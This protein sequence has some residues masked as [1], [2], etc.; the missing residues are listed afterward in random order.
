MF[1]CLFMYHWSSSSRP[2][3]FLFRRKHGEYLL[4]HSIASFL[5]II[6]IITNIMIRYLRLLL[7]LLSRVHCCFTVYQKQYNSISFNS[8]HVSSFSLCAISKISKKG[9]RRRTSDDI[10]F[11]YLCTSILSFSSS[12]FS[13]SSS[14]LYTIHYIVLWSTFIW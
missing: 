1:I 3:S 14:L 9:Y 10:L 11:Y 13:S 12:S 4:S 2:K 7:L 5:L 6:T 8:I